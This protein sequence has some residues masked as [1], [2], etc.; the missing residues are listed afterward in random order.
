MKLDKRAYCPL[1]SLPHEV[2][3]SIEVYT[4]LRSRKVLGRQRWAGTPTCAQRIEEVWVAAVIHI[5]KPGLCG[6]IE[7]PQATQRIAS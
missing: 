6:C 4:V 2:I 7:E 5:V 1:A 3:D